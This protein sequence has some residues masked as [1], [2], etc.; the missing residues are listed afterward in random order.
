MTSNV[1]ICD[2]GTGFVKCGFSGSN[3]PHAI[4]PALV[5]RPILRTEE[6]LSNTLLKDVLVGDDASLNRS[7]LQISYPLEN[8]IIRNWD[9]MLLLWDYTFY[10]RYLP[11]TESCY[12]S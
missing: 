3:F 8:G 10:E 4:F 1:I 6:K 5:G 7:S 2:N 12:R 11:L 9:E